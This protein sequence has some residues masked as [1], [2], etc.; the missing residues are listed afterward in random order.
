MI[1]YTRKRQGTLAVSAFIVDFSLA[2]NRDKSMLREKY[3]E[4]EI[5]SIL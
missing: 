5:E 4:L 2:L 1:L 3:I